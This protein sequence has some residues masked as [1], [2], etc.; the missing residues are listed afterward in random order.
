MALMMLPASMAGQAILVNLDKKTI[1][2]DSLNM[3]GNTSA[4]SMLT[5][6]PEL[7]QR[8]GGSFLSNYEIQVEGMTVNQAGD[9]ALNQL[10]IDDIE[11]IEVNESPLLSYNKNGVGGSINIVLRSHGKDGD[12][13]WGSAGLIASHP[14]NIAPQLILGHRNNSFMVRGVLMSDIYNRPSTSENITYSPE[15]EFISNSRNDINYR[16]RSQVARLYMMYEPNK[17]NTIKF[18][19]SET[20]TYEKET[21]TP[22]FVASMMNEVKNKALNL[23]TLLNYTHR[24]GN[25]SFIT[26]AQYQYNPGS[27]YKYVPG[28]QV[29]NNDFTS[30]NISGKVEFKSMLQPSSKRSTV[31]VGVGCNLNGMFTSD[32]MSSKI[33]QYSIEINRTPEN[34]TYFIQP[35]AYVELNTG[36]FHMKATGEY[37]HFRYDIRRLDED[38]KVYSN[39]FTGKLITEWH[40]SQHKCLRFIADRKLQ[41]PTNNQLFPLLGYEL[42]SMSYVKGNPYL[43]P[44]L[45]HE[46]KLDYLTDRTWGN[47]SITFNIGASYNN[48]RD[49]INAK[50]V[51]G[52][53]SPSGG[54]GATLKYTTYENGGV[55]H[56]LNANIMTLYRYKAFSLTFTGNVYHKDMPNEGNKKHYTYFNLMLHPQFTLADGWHGGA[57]F[58][59]YSKVHMHEGT[60]GECAAASLS[61]GKRWKG[62]YVYIYDIVSLQKDVKDKSTAA[63]GSLNVKEYEMVPNTFGVGIKYTL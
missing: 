32:D 48:I 30:N 45:S 14:T 55:N 24:F 46:F 56:I 25:S 28:M 50:S 16:Y 37:Q 54:F 39:D 19:V 26:E 52:S 33:I 23:H 15:G 8:P 44:M 13:L 47:N 49:I 60:L 38:Y 63:D 42:E 58:N 40:I 35:Y 27:R 6:L 41:R 62:M 31:N 43:V 12:N 21:N 22:D 51:G 57:K 61:V 10:M 3:P 11:K 1:I 20:Y 4:Y 7:L 53:T 34:N 59:Y 29:F 2:T 5:M 9:V 17:N 18:N 36:K